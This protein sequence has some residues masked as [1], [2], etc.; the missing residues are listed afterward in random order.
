MEEEGRG[1]WGLEELERVN[2]TEELAIT[3]LTQFS[4]F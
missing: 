3:S 1:F 2:V 4:A